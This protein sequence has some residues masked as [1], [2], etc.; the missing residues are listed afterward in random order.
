MK[1]IIFDLDGVLVETKDIHY[2][3]LN[4]ALKKV[5]IKYQISFDEHLKVFD[6]LPSK[7]KLE[8]LKSRKVCKVKDFNSI[9]RNKNKFTLELLEKKIIFNNKIFKMFKTL[10]K[11]YKIAVAT[12]AIESTLKLCLSRLKIANFIDFSISNEGVINPKP[13]PEI[14]MKCMMKFLIS[15]KNTLILEDSY[16]GREAAKS[17]GA[18]LMPVNNLKDVSLNN[19]KKFINDITNKK[20]AIMHQ[21]NKQF[22]WVDEDIN[23]LIPMAG[24]GSRFV[25]AGYTFPKPLIEVFGKPMIQLV[26]EN[27]SIK[28]NYT[29]VIQKHHQ[30][31][32][33]IKSML[34][35]LTPNCNFVEVDSVTE[36]AAC[37]TLL[38]KEYINNDKPLIICNSD[39]YIEM[40]VANIMYK[41][42]NKK[43]DGGIL[44]FNSIHPKWSYAKTN[45][46]N[47]VTEVAEKR[48][49]SNK[50]T[51]GIYFW[52]K[53]IEYVKYA[54]QMIQKN[55][56]VNN[57]FYVCPVFN[58]AI[59]DKKIFI[60]ENVEN[61]WGI[62]TPEDLNYFINNFEKKNNS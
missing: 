39:Q 16:V 45:E 53:G 14:Y 5:G 17:S 3:A 32:Y 31:K 51:C 1:L 18:N 59:L 26:V 57:E 21:S 33:N 15:P 6:G 62:G 37:T 41:F 4:K 40:N 52:K 60:T 19:I 54:E 58:E 46:K 47:I 10:S 61:M 22:S 7:K 36:G 28:G 12:N 44:V 34:K 24:H 55:I 13:H 49:I 35:I 8:I 20:S 42:S 27:L 23:I 56:R 9:I 38:A 11:K 2:L 25:D 29:Y 43:V 48:A 30:S 50:A